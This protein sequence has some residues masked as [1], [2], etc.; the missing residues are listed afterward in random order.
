LISKMKNAQ[1]FIINARYW[2]PGI[3]SSVILVFS[4][5]TEIL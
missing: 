5:F 1:K 3:S 4:S 2:F